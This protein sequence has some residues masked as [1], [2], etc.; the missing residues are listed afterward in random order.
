[1]ESMF[2]EVKMEKVRQL[3]NQKG[4]GYLSYGEI[5]DLLPSKTVF[6]ERSVLR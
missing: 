2:F 1:M 5:V 4:K 3:I 6:P